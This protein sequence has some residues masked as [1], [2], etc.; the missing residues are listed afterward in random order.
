MRGDETSA[1][2]GGL[3]GSGYSREDAGRAPPTCPGVAGGQPGPS[4]TLQRTLEPESCLKAPGADGPGGGCGRRP[5]ASPVSHQGRAFW[6]WRPGGGSSGQVTSEG[7][8]AEAVR[9]GRGGVT[10]VE[11]SCFPTATLP[12]GP[13]LSKRPSCPKA[14]SG[15]TW[16]TAAV[17][18]GKPMCRLPGDPLPGPAGCLSCDLTSCAVVDK[19]PLLHPTGFKSP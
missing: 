5:Q 14:V 4:L 3:G 7:A 9:T 2:M 1:W 10:G 12:S 8:G 6:P 16:T 15:A 11:R 19:N 18:L 17:T 13:V